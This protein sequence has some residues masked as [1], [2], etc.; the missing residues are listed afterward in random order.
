[1]TKKGLVEW[2]KLSSNPRAPVLPK[3]KNLSLLL[4][5]CMLDVSYD[6]KNRKNSWVLCTP[7]ILA[8]QEVEAG[9]SQ[10]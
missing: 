9:G 10:A 6:S 5:M 3:K 2:L 4:Q 1:M 8:T 7:V